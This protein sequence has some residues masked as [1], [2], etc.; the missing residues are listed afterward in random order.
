MDRNPA[1]IAATL[2]VG[3]PAAGCAH[4]TIRVRQNEGTYR[5]T[6][7]IAVRG[8]WPDQNFSRNKD[9]MVTTEFQG[10]TYEWPAGEGRM[11]KEPAEI[12]FKGHR[13]RCSIVNRRLTLDD[14][15]YGP[16]QRGD[17]VRITGDGRVFVNAVERL[18]VNGA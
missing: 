10:V 9:Y 11:S 14:R 2:M 13:I 16:F 15:R 7:Q 4:G 12:R 6:K 8:D 5:M 18:P 1:R 3:F 17:R